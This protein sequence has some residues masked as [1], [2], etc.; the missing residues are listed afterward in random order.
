VRRLSVVLALAFVAVACNP[1]SLKPGYC[2]TVND[3]KS[4]EKCNGDT[5]KCEAMM[6]T[7]GSVE[8]AEAGVDGPDA[9][10]GRDASDVAEAPP[11]T[12]RT[13]P[14]LCADGGYDGSPGVCE[15]EAGVCVECLGDGDCSQDPT[16]PVCEGHLCRP[17]K[18]DAE[19]KGGPGVCMSHQD[20]HCAT[21][22]ETIYVKNAAGCT[23]TAGGGTLAV[24]YCLSQD[25][26][27][28]VVPG[29]ALVV[30]RGPDALTEWTVATGPAAAITVVGQSGATVNPGARAGVRV[31]AGKVYV[32]DLKVSSGS[33]VGVAAETGAE[34]TMDHCAV[35]ANTKG[36]ILVDAANFD[37]TNTTVT[38][39]GPGDDAGAAWGGLRLKN[40]LTTGKKSLGFLSVTNNNQ[41]GVSCSESVDA[42]GVLVTGSAGMVEVSQSCNFKSCGNTVTATCGAQF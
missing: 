34:L 23:M 4:G 24:P 30:M 41:V 2:H 12:C 28:A 17:C 39:N 15:V 9:I 6:T 3:C 31:S 36:G 21:D 8:H 33:N 35:V 42:A 38:G 11:P 20:G 40:L 25:G 22:D 18:T 19:C 26:I 7:D 14:M 29:R 16:K 10:D 27:N 5:R 1:K 37:I 13:Q 32:R